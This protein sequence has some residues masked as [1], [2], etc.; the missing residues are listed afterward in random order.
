VRLRLAVLSSL[1]LATAAAAAFVLLGLQDA[2]TIAAPIVPPARAAVTSESGALALASMSGTRVVGLSLLPRA[3]RVRATVTVLDAAG[4]QV[5]G[6]RV[7]VGPAGAPACGAG[8]YRALLPRS[9]VGRKIVVRIGPAAKVSFTL[10]A[11]WPVSAA[12]TLERADR[13]FLAARSVVY[14]ERLQSRP[15]LALDTTWQMVAPNRLR[16]RIRGGSSAVIIGARRWDR[17][18]G[19]E[20]WIASDQEALTLPGLPWR[21]RMQN[22]V[23]LDPP[24]D[25]SRGTIRFAMLDPADSAWYEATVDAKTSLLREL[26]MVAPSHL[27]QEHYVSYGTQVRITPPAQG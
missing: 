12:A 19:S 9:V 24:T 10:P 17:A 2:G 13:A 14:R 6:L 5:R 21:P 27:M 20:R 11:R 23:R 1:A 22:V 15:G 7:R 3:D 4:A 25:D 26:R 18:A 16:Y 8:C